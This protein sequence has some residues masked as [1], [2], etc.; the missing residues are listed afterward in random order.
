MATVT[1]EEISELS[2]QIRLV[3]IKLIKKYGWAVARHWTN[4]EEI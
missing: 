2:E 1:E 3:K 4:L